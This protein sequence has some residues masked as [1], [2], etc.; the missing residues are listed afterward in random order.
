MKAKHSIKTTV[1][2][3]FILCVVVMAL[4]VGGF[5]IISQKQFFAVAQEDYEATK[6]EGYEKEIKSQVET[7]I[8]VLQAA[9]DKV[10]AGV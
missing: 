1:K 7:A 4:F 6:Q 2:F 10:Q 5:S 8:A 3:F 9:Y